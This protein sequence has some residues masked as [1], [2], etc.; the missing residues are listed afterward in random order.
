ML[1]QNE[2]LITSSYA[3]WFLGS[4][5]TTGILT[6]GESKAR[7]SIISNFRKMP[8]VKVATIN[9]CSLALIRMWD[10]GAAQIYGI[11]V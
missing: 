7:P 1:V 4:M 10:S 5:G 3:P 11:G 2:P 6:P 9:P 8:I